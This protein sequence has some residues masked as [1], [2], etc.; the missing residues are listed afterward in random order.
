VFY[1]V[2]VLPGWLRFISRLLPITWSLEGIRGALLKGESFSAL[3]QEFLA[4]AIIA[5][6]LVPL[7]LAFFRLS[8]HYARKT[9]TLVK[10]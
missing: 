10:Y 1:P 7:G 3:W 4:L 5:S 6:V 2:S 8:V 9:G